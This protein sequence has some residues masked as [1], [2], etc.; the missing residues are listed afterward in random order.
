[1][2][3]INKITGRAADREPLDYD[4]SS[5]ADDERTGSRAEV[6]ESD[7]SGADDALG[8][9]LRQMGAIPLLNR[10]QELELAKRLEAKRERF[11]RAALT[12]PRILERVFQTFQ[13]VNDGQLALDPTIDAVAS[14]G[15]GREEILRRIPTHLKT[16]RQL[17]KREGDAFAQYLLADSA[18]ARHKCRRQRWRLIRKMEKLVWELSPR[19]ELLEHWVEE[20]K[21]QAEELHTLARRLEASGLTGSR[22]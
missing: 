1:M 16:L 9:Y 15:L 20:L 12:S 8:L 7:S 22:G 3:R 5:H 14:L 10:S 17:L 19:T 18:R 2:K 13:K 4:E 21:V 6:H 11:R